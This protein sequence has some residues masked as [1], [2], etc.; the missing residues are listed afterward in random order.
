MWLPRMDVDANDPLGQRRRS[1]QTSRSGIENICEHGTGKRQSRR[2]YI[3]PPIAH[4]G[5]PLQSANRADMLTEM[6]RQDIQVIHDLGLDTD[7]EEYS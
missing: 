3:L 7:I 1:D 4:S 5:E 2:T 6:T